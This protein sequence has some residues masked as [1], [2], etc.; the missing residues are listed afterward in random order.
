MAAWLLDC[1]CMLVC[2]QIRDDVLHLQR[3]GLDAGICLPVPARLA[4]TGPA[5]ASCMGT[6]A[7]LGSLHC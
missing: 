4:G 3:F 7:H 2:L 1:G 6:L 5:L